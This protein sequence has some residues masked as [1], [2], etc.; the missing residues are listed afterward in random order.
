MRS[1]I[2]FILV[3]YIFV[4]AGCSSN[5]SK[6][7]IVT[8]SGSDTMFELTSKLAEEYMKDHPGISVKV[9]G[10]GTAAGIRQLIKG[11]IDICT[12]SRNL[13]PEEAKDL[14]DYY[15]S[16][17]L[18]FL[19]AKDALSI[20][21]HPENPV[22]NLTFDQLKK[23][24]IGDINN[25][26]L[27]GGIDTLIQPLTRNPNSGT[28]LYFK[29]HILE[30]EEYVNSS[31]IIP[32]TREIVRYVEQ[33]INAIGYGGMGYTGKVKHIKI[34]GVEPTETNVINDTYPII[35]YLHFFTTKSPGGEVKRF[36]DWVLS[37]AGQSVVRKSGFI[38]L[39]EN[40]L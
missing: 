13:K 16:L 19:I 22:K 37:S 6:G 18:V 36:I 14:A 32:T 21:L 29:E 3:V 27:V 28:Y 26:K 5:I 15:G 9:D 40:K 12:A 1:K 35:R 11:S 23:I 10:G 2:L 33:N 30:A 20:Y 31:L 24:Y 4:A 17:G 8:I 34:D 39:W 38:P 7:N 25:W